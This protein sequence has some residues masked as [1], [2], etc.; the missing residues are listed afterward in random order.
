VSD[1]ALSTFF[2]SFTHAIS[3]PSTDQKTHSPRTTTTTNPSRQAEK[4]EWVRRWGSSGERRW[5]VME[6]EKKKA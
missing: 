2:V 6:G 3:I 4:E 1:R 5:L